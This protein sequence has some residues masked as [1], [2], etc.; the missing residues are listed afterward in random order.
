MSFSNLSVSY[1]MVYWLPQS[2]GIF[3]GNRKKNCRYIHGLLKTDI[4]FSLGCTKSAKCDADAEVSP[5]SLKNTSLTFSILYS[6]YILTHRSSD[7]SP[8]SETSR[9]KIRVKTI[10]AQM[11]A[12]TFSRFM[13]MKAEIRHSQMNMTIFSRFILFLREMSY[14]YFL[15]NLFRSAKVSDFPQQA[16]DKL[17]WRDHDIFFYHHFHTSYFRPRRVAGHRAVEVIVCLSYTEQFISI[18]GLQ[19]SQRHTKRI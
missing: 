10:H 18:I 5:C 6:I 3:F 8:L 12:A 7:I 15:C 16:C 17:L 13:S 9:K 4:K 14:S 19:V 1:F 11:I 2:Y